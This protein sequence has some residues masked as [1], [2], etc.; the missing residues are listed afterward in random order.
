M[1]AVKAEW[2]LWGVAPDS[3]GDYAVLSCSDGRLRP[4]H[5]E[6]I[7]T[8][9]SPGTPDAEGALPRVTIGAVDVSKVP[10]LGMALQTLQPDQDLEATTTRFFFFPFRALSD[11]PVAY[12]DLYEHLSRIDLPESGSGPLVTVD[13]PALDPTPIVEDLRETGPDAI[14]AAALLALD[15]QVCVTRAEATTLEER[16]R[17][18]DAVAAQ[19]PYGYRAKLTATTW[20]NNATR[21]R[22]RLSFARNAGGGAVALP[23]RGAA[24]VPADSDVEREY[25]AALAAAVDRHGAPEVIRRLAADRLPR[26]CDDPGPALAALRAMTRTSRPPD[27]L[28]PAEVRALLEDESAVGGLD[29]AAAREALGRL[30]RLAEP[31]DW[32]TVERWWRELAGED[33]ATLRASLLDRCRGPLWSGKRGEFQPELLLAYRN[34]QGDEF[35][36]ELV[37]PPDGPG[38]AAERGLRTAAR[39]VHDSVIVPGAVSAHPRTLRTL[40]RHPPLLCAFVALLSAAGR[41]RLLQG[42]AWLESADGEGSQELT[43]FR[44]VLLAQRPVALSPERLRRLG[45]SGRGCVAALLEAACEAGRSQLVLP[46]F[47]ETLAHGGPLSPADSRYWAERLN[48]LHPADTAALGAIDVLLLVLGGRPTLPPRL[49][50]RSAEDYRRGVLDIWRLPWPDGGGPAPA[51][52]ALL[53]ERPGAEGSGA[54]REM[55]SLLEE[56]SGG[57]AERPP[58]QPPDQ[59]ERPPAQPPDQAT[60]RPRATVTA[61]EE[62]SPRQGAEAILHRLCMGYRRGLTLD[63]CARRLRAEPWTPTA[64]LAVTVVRGLAQALVE[65]GASPE[66]AQG[67]SVELAQRLASGEFGRGLAR[68]FR[69]ELLTAVTADVRDLLVLL[70]AVADEGPPLAGRHRQELLD[71]HTELGR[72]LPPPPSRERPEGV[73]YHKADRR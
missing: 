52:K 29:A 23:W 30:I 44:D 62:T 6:K 27:E 8:R 9:F 45:E 72:L 65:H 1:A 26:S 33:A 2:A 49:P 11:G 53:R 16:L 67:W 61:D 46:A 48:D 70:S 58:A 15:R 73:R 22:L 56:F 42:M 31:R 13:P 37:A 55:R 59:A 17:F 50:A 10:H 69:R 35:L 36:A 24:P 25:T 4:S 14:R 7:I 12:R 63:T 3:D 57:P 38:E 43:V 51:V 64:A 47:G 21:H 66:I 71:V 18:L 32:P 20:A 41:N 39:L 19:L 40:H 60:N 34:G 54:L 5:F 68:R 28:D